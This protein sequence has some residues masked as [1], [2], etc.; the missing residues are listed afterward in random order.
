MKY[1]IIDANIAA[2]YYLKRSAKTQK[3]ADIIENIIDYCR[4]NRDKYFI[5]IPNFCIAET[6]SVFI[7]HSFAKWNKHLKGKKP[8]DTRI[9]K[10]LIES[11][12]NDIHNGK[13]M[14]HYE[15][16]RYHVLGINL[17]API[18]HY[19]KIKRSSSQKGGNSV[20]PAG[21]FDHL[22]I[23]MGINLAHIHGS[24]NVW[25][26]TTDS[27]LSLVL[28]KCKSGIKKA[29]LKKLKIEIAENVTGKKYSDKIFPNHIDLSNCKKQELIDLF[30]A[31]PL[32]YKLSKSLKVKRC[33]K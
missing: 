5:Y 31:W 13:F 25:V 9:Y 18:D 22:I 2:G 15:L 4:C 21:T 32:Q 33:I 10:S 26:L 23:S 12:Y 24:E 11:F 16:N 3:A 20:I 27:R 30:G 29:S 19:Y 17:V 6:I 28:S 7:K 1:L 14:Y 8:I